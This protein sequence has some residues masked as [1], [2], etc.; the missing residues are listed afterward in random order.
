MNR[1]EVQDMLADARGF[2]FW[3]YVVVDNAVFHLHIF[4]ELLLV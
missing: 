2:L 1:P 4:N 3:F